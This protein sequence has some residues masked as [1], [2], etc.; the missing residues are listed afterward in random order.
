[1]QSDLTSKS[2]EELSAMPMLCYSCGKPIRH[3]SLINTLKSGKNLFQTLNQLNYE[4]M[5]CRN[6]IMTDAS[7]IAL[8]KQLQNEQYVTNQLSNLTLETTGPS[9]T[10]PSEGN[11]HIINEAPTD[12]IQ[13]G[14][15]MFGD[16]YIENEDI[17]P[18]EFFIN[19]LEMP[20]T[21]DAED[22]ENPHF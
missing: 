13:N 12:L 22:E 7:I 14:L 11:L 17:N 6:V 5:C 16:S 1:M 4:R 20:N 2:F 19:E 10:I 9:F 15:A 21:E 18:Y 3:M 8:Q